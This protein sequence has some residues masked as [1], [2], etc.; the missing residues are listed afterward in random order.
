M[1]ICF[2]FYVLHVVILISPLFN[3]CKEILNSKQAYSESVRT[4]KGGNV[5]PQAL[6][7]ASEENTTSLWGIFAAITL[8]SIYAVIQDLRKEWPRIVDAHERTRAEISPHG[9][10]NAEKE[11]VENVTFSDS[12]EGAT[13][14]LTAID[15][16]LRSQPLNVDATLDNFF[17]RPVKIFEQ[18]WGV[19]SPFAFNIDPWSLYFTNP[20]VINRIAN[21]K[22]M[23]ADLNVKVIL[24]GNAFHYG[25]CIVAYNP[26]PQD[27]NLTVDRAFIDADV[28]AASQRPHIWLNPTNSQGGDLKLPF[29]Y[30]KNLIDVV[31]QEWSKMGE[32]V[33]HSLQP[34][35]HA[36]GATDTVTV[37]VFAWAENVQFSIPT[38]VEPGAIAPQT[39]NISPHGDEY[40]TK[41]VSRIAGAV[42][43]MAGYLTQMPAIAPYA[44]ATEI[45][46]QAV[47]A[48]AT[49]FGF[50]SP[51]M[52]EV[53][54]YRP[55]PK[56]NLANTNVHND[57]NK[58]TMDVKQ[59]LSVDP[60]T[61]GLPPDDQMTISHIASTESYLVEFPW[62]V[63]TSPET[64]LW[65][66]VVDPSI[67]RALGSERHFPAPAFAVMPFKYWRGTMRF[68][69]MVVS[70]NYHKGRLKVVYDP[71]GGIGEAEY[72][73]AYTTIVDISDETDFTVDVGW[74]QA[75]TWREHRAL[76]G[77]SLQ[78]T[79]PI[80]YTS[81][82]VDYGNGTLS[83]YVVNE[84]TVPNTVSN[85]DIAINV[86]VSMGDDFEV[87]V[88]RQT[89]IGSLRMTPDPPAPPGRRNISPHA[90]EGST[91][92][93]T[94]G[95]HI[96]TMANKT[97]ISD[98]S[99]LFHFGEAIGSMRQYIKR[100]V[101]TEYLSAPSTAGRFLSSYYRTHFPL[102]PGY[103]P[104]GGSAGS[105]PPNYDL[106]LGEYT[107]TFLT[108][109]SYVASAY[110][111]VRGGV[112]YALDTTPLLTQGTSV[113]GV[114]SRLDNHEFPRTEFYTVPNAGG[115]PAPL[116][117]LT[118]NIAS[119]GA[120]LSSEVNPVLSFEVPY[121]SFYRFAP[122]KRWNRLLSES[123]DPFT[124]TWR[125]TLQGDMPNESTDVWMP[126]Y[127]AAG[128]DFS[129]FW[130]LG[131]PIFYVDSSFPTS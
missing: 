120:M 101:Q 6:D 96:E 29:F 131:P 33:A 82:S 124:H 89:A 127:T 129:C 110:A 80:G 99:S 74:G 112:R 19:G 63:T 14:G 47:G 128:E 93:P 58:L 62:D 113:N 1:F 66:C 121:Y 104:D 90:E 61:V 7:G 51:V 46:A 59:E 75:T 118:S 38:Q 100:Y 95:S 123:V 21:Y 126:M 87:C 119:G 28:V 88:P 42:A 25:R 15:D 45:G 43:K 125:L 94:G 107:F 65:Q 24:N 23:R 97:T 114:V 71:E 22:L 122:A 56:T 30:Y 27:D 130:Y 3:I 5:R 44:R 26:L 20:R 17:S 60:R 105:F 91:V 48:M 64:L 35:K 40:G 18:D 102:I 86:F 67:H 72:N 11:T 84:L 2:M 32:L 12:H 83:V 109:L 36:N 53:S 52:T 49:L 68:R 39:A 106:T 41:P 16:P 117:N 13:D 54:Q 9:E 50:S 116:M 73:T 70:S 108:P 92:T 78:D 98:P 31:G 57:A 81:S 8:Y 79:S 85:N 115:N 4:S 37:S 34:L 111:G 10:E 76:A 77:N 69:F 103:A 55:L